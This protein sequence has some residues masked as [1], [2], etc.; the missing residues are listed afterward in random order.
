P[1][2]QV[3]DVDAEHERITALG[4]VIIEPPAS[5]PWGSRSMEFRDPDGNIINFFQRI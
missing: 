3:A 1:D 5:Y 2:V 4:A